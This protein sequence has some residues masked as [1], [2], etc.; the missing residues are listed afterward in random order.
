MDGELSQLSHEGILIWHSLEHT[1]VHPPSASFPES[2]WCRPQADSQQP[3]GCYLPKY[4]H[5][6][7]RRVMHGQPVPCAVRLHVCV[8]VFV[9]VSRRTLCTAYAR[10]FCS[11]HNQRHPLQC[12]NAMSHV[13]CRKNRTTTA[14]PLRMASVTSP[15]PPPPPPPGNDPHTNAT[16]SILPAAQTH[17]RARAAHSAHDSEGEGWTKA[18][19]SPLEATATATCWVRV[20]TQEK[21]HPQGR[22][23]MYTQHSLA[24]G[25]SASRV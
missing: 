19:P 20:T 2:V 10:T 25:W 12:D 18:G 7:C 14:K 11:P 16:G 13:T 23:I 21:I 8:C 24:M 17:T 4:V 22:L 15:P 1:I 6:E 9:S 3:A 5:T